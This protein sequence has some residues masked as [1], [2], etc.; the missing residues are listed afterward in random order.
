MVI[1]EERSLLP[2]AVTSSTRVSESSRSPK[3]TFKWLHLAVLVL[4]FAWLALLSVLT[5]RNW[6]IM[7]PQD[8]EGFREVRKFSNEI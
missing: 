8:F 5:A 3:Q 4:I 2:T 7:M 6:Q 1:K